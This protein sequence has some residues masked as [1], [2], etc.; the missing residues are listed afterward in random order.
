MGL[1]GLVGFQMI[2]SNESV[3]FND[4][5]EFD[6]PRYS[7]IPVFDDLQEISIRRMDFDNPKVYGVIP[8]SPMVSLF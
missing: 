8:P 1:V 2:I 7:M 6:D 3:D 5:K 4:P